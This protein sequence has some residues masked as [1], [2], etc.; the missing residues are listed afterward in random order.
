MNKLQL[1]T[2]C[3]SKGLNRIPEDI[4]VYDDGFIFLQDVEISGKPAK[5]L[6][7]GRVNARWSTALLK[8][9]MRSIKKRNGLLVSFIDDNFYEM[10]AATVRTG[11]V[12]LDNDY[13]YWGEL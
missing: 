12:V 10:R 8:G 7:V 2:L 4:A 13:C 11:G 5:N 3:K 9:V 6:I 1:L